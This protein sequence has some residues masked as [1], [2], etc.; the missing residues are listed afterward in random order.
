MASIPDIT[1]M[2]ARIQDWQAGHGKVGGRAEVVRR[3]DEVHALLEEI[4]NML[5]QARTEMLGAGRRRWH[6]RGE[7]PCKG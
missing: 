2:L 4:S 6:R 5:A 1:R 7:T 3:L